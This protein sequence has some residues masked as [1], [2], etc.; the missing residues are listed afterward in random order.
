MEKANELAKQN[1]DDTVKQIEQV[2]TE[3]DKIIA[4]RNAEADYT[5]ALQ[6]AKDGKIAHGKTGLKEQVIALTVE[7]KRLETENKRLTRDNEDLFNRHKGFET[8][9]SVLSNATKAISLFRTHEPEAFTR[10]FYRASGILQA[11]I[12]P[13]EAPA[14]LGRN[15]LRE[16]E[17]EIKRENELSKNKSNNSNNT[18]SK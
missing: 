10:V 14:N 4:E 2:K 6:E 15:R 12:P 3:R 9:D 18:N 16:I 8:N 17:E 11:F 7:N 13:S 5:K 1:F